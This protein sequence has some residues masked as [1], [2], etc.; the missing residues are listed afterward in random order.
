MRMSR[1]TKVKDFILRYYL[2]GPYKRRTLGPFIKG[3][4]GVKEINDKL[5]EIVKTHKNDKGLWTQDPAISEKEKGVTQYQYVMLVL[6]QSTKLLRI[7]P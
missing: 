5:Y 3:T 7:Y 2:K 4:F 6:D 1:A